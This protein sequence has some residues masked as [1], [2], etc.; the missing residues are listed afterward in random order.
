[1]DIRVAQ[2]TPY[3][4]QGQASH[5]IYVSGKTIPF[6][7]ETPTLPVGQEVQSE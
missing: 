2:V 6:N 3:L 1:M 7:P 5:A 4:S